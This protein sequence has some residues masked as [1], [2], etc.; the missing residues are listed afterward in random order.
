MLPLLALG[1]AG[2]TYDVADLQ[3]DITG[4]LPAAAETMRVCV[5]G[6]G[7]LDLGA[8]NGRAAFTGI[9][10]GDPIRRRSTSPEPT[11]RSSPARGRPSSTRPRPT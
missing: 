9:P 5:A 11:R 1:C 3:L 8:G 7:I 6:V 10:I 2:E 4:P